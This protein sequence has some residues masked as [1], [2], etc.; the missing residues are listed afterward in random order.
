MTY[1]P[2]NPGYPP[3]VGSY[4]GAVASA[5]K[6][7]SGPNKLPFYLAVVVVVL[8]V[9]AYLASFG[10]IFILD[11]ELGLGAG[12]RIGGSDFVFALTLLAALL[13]GLNLL[14][15]AKSSLGVNVGVV[16]AVAV[17]GTLLVIAE[18]I[19]VPSGVA[20]GWAL[21]LVLTCSVFQAVTAVAAAL[22]ESGVI[23][24]PAPRPS[25]DPYGQYGQYGQYGGYYPGAQQPTGHQSAQPA[26][27]GAHYGGYSSA[28]GPRPGHS[29]GFAGQPGSPAGAQSSPQSTGHQG[30]ATPPTGFP[31]FSP[32]PSGNAAPINYSNPSGGQQS[33]EQGQQSS[34][35]PAPA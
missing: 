19:N 20:I 35:G 17:L 26:G 28:P 31:S 29:G 33:Y 7:E 2:G 13:A 12:E 3:P 16:A 4:G 34:S 25:Y 32:P 15:K 6:A 9:V 14:P 27:Y 21:W 5:E 8:G 24:P 18:T 23:T 10:P 30:S 11:A 1:S 22:L